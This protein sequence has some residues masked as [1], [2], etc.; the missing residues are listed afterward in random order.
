[1]GTV[2]PLTP[3]QRSASGVNVRAQIE[4]AA[5]AALDTAEHLIAL[6]GRMDDEDRSGGTPEVSAHQDT[7]TLIR[8]DA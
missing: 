7:A 3:R 5:Q 8:Q 4:E 2:H 1:M 6:L